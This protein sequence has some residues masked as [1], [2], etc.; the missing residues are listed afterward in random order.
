MPTMFDVPKND[1]IEAIAK[2]LQNLPELNPPDWATFAKTGMHKERP[3][4]RDDWWYVRAA[5]ILLTVRSKG[6][7][8]V[9]KMRRKYGGRKNRGHKPDKSFK[10]GGSIIRKIL[11]QLESAELVKQDEKGVH[12]GRV[13]TPKGVSLADVSAGKLY[14][15]VSKS[16]KSSGKSEKNPEE[17]KKEVKKTEPKKEEKSSEKKTEPKKEEKPK[18]KKTEP[19]KEEKKVETKPVEKKKAEPKKEEKVEPKKEEKV[20]PKKE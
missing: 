7:I 17:P 15:P 18:E 10:G 11:Q 4:M 8:G 19:K 1:L 12:K 16:S 6:P 3:P 2:E 13:L 20:E 14:T 5:S 9:S